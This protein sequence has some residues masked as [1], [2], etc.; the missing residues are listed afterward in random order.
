M[1][2]T[3]SKHLLLIIT[4]SIAAY[5]SLDVIRRAREADWRVTPV[6]T[7]GAQ[8]FITPMAAAALAESPAYTDIF[9]LKD[10]TEMGHIRLAREA[11]AVLVAPA[12]ADI[13]AKM[14]AGLADDLASTLLLATRAPVLVAPAMNTAMWEHPATQRNVSAL[15]AY[16]VRFVEP[17]EGVLACG[18][19]GAGKLATAEDI[20][21]ALDAL[22]AAGGVKQSLRGAHVVV[23]AGPT[24]EPIDPV[25]FISNHSS[26]KQG[27]ALAETLA[28]A[29][30]KVTL[31]SGPTALPEPT[32]RGITFVGIRTATEMLD[33]VEKALPADVYIGVA[34]VADWRMA[35]T[36]SQKIKKKLDGSVPVF[37][38]V[39]NPDIL[40]TV[41]TH[42]SKRLRTWQ[43]ACKAL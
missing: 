31:I 2:T 12:S 7:R 19:E 10:E 38:L 15:K 22:P 36:Q 5:K 3:A 26:G 14:Q 24:Q 43:A 6:L 13:L 40:A 35:N 41:A 17:A 20:L 8:E 33:A 21:A 42:R 30:A 32:T 39:P 1:T 37:K 18:E 28:A 4:G 27:Y 25:R 9:S 34:A 16:G 23:T 29:G 11:D